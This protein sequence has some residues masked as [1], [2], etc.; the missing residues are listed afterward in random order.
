MGRNVGIIISLV[1]GV[2]A[3]GIGAHDRL[4]STA[5]TAEAASEV[6]T[7]PLAASSAPE[8]RDLVA[9]AEV[10][11]DRS[12]FVKA[13]ETARL[14]RVL[15]REGPYTVFA[16]VDSAFE[17]IPQ[18]TI[19]H[20]MEPANRNRLRQLLRHH[21]VLGRY[22]TSLLKTMIQDS[23]E[24]QVTLVTLAKAPLKATLEG[25]AIVIQDSQGN[26]TR[27]LEGDQVARNGVL[28]DIDSIVQSRPLPG[29][30]VVAPAVLAE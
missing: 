27:I 25:E 10:D 22:D 7:I 24:K 20:L 13:L 29:R 15:Q 26:R 9:K 14:K 21:M 3:I 19:T 30:S 1:L 23:P 8:K 6:K 16:P 12:V 2:A 11:K 4:G 28:H 18:A 17:A 5:V